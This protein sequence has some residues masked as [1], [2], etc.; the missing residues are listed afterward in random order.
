MKKIV[1]IISMLIC[2]SN[3]SSGQGNLQFNQAVIVN[4]SA[5]LPTYN[6]ST[7]TSITVPAGKVWKIEH[8]DAWIQSSLRQTQQSE[9][10][11]YI[12]NILLRRYKGSSGTNHQ[13]TDR[14]PVW[15]PAGTYSVIISNEDSTPWSFVGAINAIE[16]NIIP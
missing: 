5:S 11:L 12:D 2:L 6:T 8:A 15:L 3:Y 4:F 10:S 14:L 16:F 13:Y 9:H 1:T 7:A